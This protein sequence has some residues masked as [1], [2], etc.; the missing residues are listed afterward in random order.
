MSDLAFTHTEIVYLL[1][2]WVRGQNVPFS[3][4]SALSVHGRYFVGLFVPQPQIIQPYSSFL[5]YVTTLRCSDQYMCT[6]KTF[7]VCAAFRAPKNA[8][9][10]PSCYRQHR[11]YYKF[12]EQVSWKQY[13]GWI[14]FRE[15]WAFEIWILWQ[16]EK[17]TGPHSSKWCAKITVYRLVLELWWIIWDVSR[18]M[19]V[20]L[21]NSIV[22]VTAILALFEIVLTINLECKRCISSKKC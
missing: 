6:H 2:A 11:I 22:V 16:I 17:I 14:Q 21:I 15:M 10:E 1:H 20:Y 18:D 3:F 9:T 8:K 19:H 4:F 12:K 13:F 7:I 5:F